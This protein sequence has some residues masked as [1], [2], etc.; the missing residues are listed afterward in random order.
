MAKVKVMDGER[1]LKLMTCEL[2]PGSQVLAVAGDGMEW[3]T[4]KKIT[5]VELGSVG[6]KTVYEI[7]YLE[8][9][10]VEMLGA[11]VRRY[12]KEGDRR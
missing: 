7:T 4:V 5:P 11:S 9:A 1:V 10:R 3:L 8:C 2:R 12:T 6:E